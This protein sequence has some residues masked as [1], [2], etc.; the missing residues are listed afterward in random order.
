MAKM[1]LDGGTEGKI[2]QNGEWIRAYSCMPHNCNC[3]SLNWSVI[4]KADG[5]A[6]TVCYHNDDDNRD[7][8]YNDVS[9]EE[10]GG[11]CMPS[12]R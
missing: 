12:Q 8:W 7:G 5:K 1:I 10:N 11:N 4:I 9:V 2:S 6:G 3:G